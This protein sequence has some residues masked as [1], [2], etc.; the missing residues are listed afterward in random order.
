MAI[1]IQGKG[2]RDRKGGRVSRS[3]TPSFSTC[4]KLSVDTMYI[5]RVTADG[6]YRMTNETMEITYW[7]KKGLIKPGM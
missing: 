2:E 4:V 6:R 5:K 7:W 1:L 3:W